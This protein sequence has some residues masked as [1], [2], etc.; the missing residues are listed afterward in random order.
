MFMKDLNRDEALKSLREKKVPCD[1]V[2]EIEEVLEDPQLKFGG[3]IQ[4]V[5]HPISGR[6]G[7]KVAGFPI[8]FSESKV[9]LLEPAPYPGQHNDEIYKELLGIPQEEIEKLKKEE[10]I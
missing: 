2:P 6:T 10:V 7:I 4:E 1:A 9:E 8:K 3:M 5:I